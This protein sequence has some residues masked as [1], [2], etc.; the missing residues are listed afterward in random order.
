MYYNGT[1]V[2]QEYFKAAEAFAKACDDGHD[3][4]CYNL[5]YMYEKGYG[6]RLDSN[7]A[8]SLYEKNLQKMELE[9]L[10]LI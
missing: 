10:V 9:L 4:T 6:V 1:Q 2:E 5:A 3:K 7:K 8:L